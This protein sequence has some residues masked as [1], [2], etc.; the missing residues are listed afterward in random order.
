MQRYEDESEKL[1]LKKSAGYDGVSG[2]TAAMQLYKMG[3][4]LN[5]RKYSHITGYRKYGKEFDYYMGYYEWPC[6]KP[7][8]IHDFLMKHKYF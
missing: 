7:G 6:M 4:D 3:L 8:A 1:L 2:D 5:T